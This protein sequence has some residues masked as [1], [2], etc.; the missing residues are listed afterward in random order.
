MKKK[1]WEKKFWSLLEFDDELND[2]F[3]S[4]EIT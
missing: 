1:S 4:G 2:E 3:K